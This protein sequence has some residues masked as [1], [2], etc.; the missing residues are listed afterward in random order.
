MAGNVKVG[1]NV[2]ATHTGAEGAGTV[3][4]SNVTASALKMSSSGNTITDSAGNAVLSESSGTVN[5]NKGTVGSSVVFPSGHPIQVKNFSDSTQWTWGATTSFTTI[6]TSGDYLYMSITPKR[7]D[8][9]LLIR[10]YINFNNYD[11]PTYIRHFKLHDVTNNT[12]PVIGNTNGNR[13]QCTL[14]RRANHADQNSSD[15]LDL[16][17]IVQSL[18]TN[19]RTYRIE[20]RIEQGSG[21]W[22]IN[23]SGNDNTYYGWS[24]YSFGYIMEFMP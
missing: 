17:A 5:I 6:H 21:N 20:G 2:I 10:W 16:T 13:H 12:Y 4:L 19:A 9:R 3:T 8:S 7:S 18:N 14:S 23:H 11:N 22:Y 15:A 1:G 24:G